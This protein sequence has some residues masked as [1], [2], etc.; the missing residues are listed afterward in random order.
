MATTAVT[1]ESQ[2]DEDDDESL[3]L[4]LGLAAAA[5]RQPKRLQHGV[6]SGAPAPTD[7]PG[8]EATA[9]LQLCGVPETTTSDIGEAAVLP[10]PDVR[11]GQELIQ[12]P[13]HLDEPPQA[14]AYEGREQ[15]YD[16]FR[17][18][19]RLP[20]SIGGVPLTIPMPPIDG[21]MAVT[22]A[23]VMDAKRRRDA[24]ANEPPQLPLPAPP[25]PRPTPSSTARVDDGSDDDLDGIDALELEPG[26]TRDITKSPQHHRL[27]LD[28]WIP[29]DDDS[30]DESHRETDGA[31]DASTAKASADSCTTAAAS[32]ASGTFTAADQAAT[33]SSRAPARLVGKTLDTR[34]AHAAATAFGAAEEDVS[35]EEGEWEGGADA[36]GDG[37]TARATSPGEPRPAGGARGLPPPRPAG[38]A[39]T[40]RDTEEIT[41]DAETERASRA[42]P[43]PALPASP[44]ASVTLVMPEG[45][46][47]VTPFALD[48]EF[49]YDSIPHTERFSVA[50]ALVEG[51]Y[52]DREER[53]S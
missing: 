10:D 26:G 22:G 42:M 44:P 37:Q 41:L 49:D 47:E 30:E 34:G 18:L 11:S 13:T 19:L 14:P 31:A 15:T 2:L 53:S 39:P 38:D 5:P 20:P 23:M 17:Q 7:A 48:P 16:E 32:A 33:A 24:A 51:E 50:R 45:E 1:E 8:P 4:S 40:P 52:Y 35:E 43:P 25:L 28:S 9:S 36:D 29:D 46:E 21:M 3:L 6:E 27:Q 12:D